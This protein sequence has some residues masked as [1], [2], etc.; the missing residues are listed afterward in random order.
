MDLAS[1]SGT[2]YLWGLV[3]FPAGVMHPNSALLSHYPAVFRGPHPKRVST[4][5]SSAAVCRL[6]SGG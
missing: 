4:V 1:P 5:D 2:E 6:E 3:D